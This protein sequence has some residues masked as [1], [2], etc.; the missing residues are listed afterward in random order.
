MRQELIS[1]K[2]E[3][4]A[5]KDGE[6]VARLI[7]TALHYDM[8]DYVISLFY[9]D[10]MDE[11]AKIALLAALNHN[12]SRNRRDYFL[13]KYGFDIESPCSPSLGCLPE[14]ELEEARIEINSRNRRF[15]LARKFIEEYGR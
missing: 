5:Q 9:P 6:V 4:L 13:E 10:G 12:I 15:E 14:H 11:E 7:S 8:L 1:A 2:N 3:G